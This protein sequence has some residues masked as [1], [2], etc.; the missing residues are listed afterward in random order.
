MKK[1]F[2]IVNKFFVFTTLL[3]TQCLAEIREF[4]P[5]IEPGIIYSNNVYQSANDEQSSFI[6]SIEAGLYSRVLSD[7]QNFILKYNVK[8]LFYSHDSEEKDT[9]QKLFFTADKK[10]HQSGLKID[11]IA[12][13]YNIS[14]SINNNPNADIYSKNTIESKNAEIGVSFLTNPRSNIDFNVRAYGIV[15]DNEDNVGNYDG[16]GA[17]VDFNNG[18]NQKTFFWKSSGFYDEKRDRNDSSTTNRSYFTGTLG[19]QNQYRVSPLVRVNYENYDGVSDLDSE[20]MF[21]WGPGIRYF[22]T[23]YSYFELSYNFSEKESVSNFFGG[24]FNLAPSPRLL[25]NFNYDKRYFGDAYYFMLRNKSRRLINTVSYTEDTNNFDRD[26]YSTDDDIEVFTLNRRLE[27]LT[28]LSGRLNR[29]ALKIFYHEKDPIND[30]SS[31]E[32]EEGVGISLIGT[33]ILSRRVE[34]KSEITYTRYKF[35]RS[36]SLIQKDAY[37][38]FTLNGNYKV[39]RNVSTKIAYDFNKRSSNIFNR[40]YSENRIYLDFKMEW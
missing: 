38:D 20:E 32:E 39:Y 40:K 31:I 4:T 29:H 16:Y 10:I 17:T 2:K 3:S 37:F 15:T 6:T 24:G 7:E 5:Y 22:I 21:S 11:T 9:Y 14:E 26:F 13:I 23:K 19:Y 34:I 8:Q 35:D 12:T 30:N 36:S 25:L 33:Y 18:L 27:W 1:R 28:E